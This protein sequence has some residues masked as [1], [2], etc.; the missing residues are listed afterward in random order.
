MSAGGRKYPQRVRPIIQQKPKNRA[1]HFFGALL[2]G[3]LMWVGV[4]FLVSILF[5]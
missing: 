4:I 5:F 3:A 2:V 1:R